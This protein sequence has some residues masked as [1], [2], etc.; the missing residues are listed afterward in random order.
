MRGQAD[1]AIASTQLAAAQAILDRGVGKAGQSPALPVMAGSRR[2]PR[3]W[4][5]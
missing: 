3:P 5:I 1:R 2:F 4:D